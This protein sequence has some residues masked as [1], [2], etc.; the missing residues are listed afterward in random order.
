MVAFSLVLCVD[1][2]AV[3]DIGRQL[4]SNQGEGGIGSCCLSIRNG[5]SDRHGNRGEA[6][7]A[8]DAGAGGKGDKASPRRVDGVDCRRVCG[9]RAK[10]AVSLGHWIPVL[11]A[12]VRAGAEV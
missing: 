8:D 4:L 6:A 12:R 2:L 3:G 7:D 9:W 10:H 11:V 5:C 1:H